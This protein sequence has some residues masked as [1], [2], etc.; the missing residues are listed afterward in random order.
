MAKTIWTFPTRIKPNFWEILFSISELIS[1]NINIV[2]WRV[3]EDTT[4][5][6]VFV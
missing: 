1:E 2:N 4:I 6:E 3:K 5:S